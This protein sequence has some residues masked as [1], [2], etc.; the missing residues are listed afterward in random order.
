MSEVRKGAGRQTTYM[1]AGVVAVV[2][3]A[4]ILLSYSGNIFGSTGLQTA[5]QAKPA[6]ETQTTQSAPA[7]Q[8]AGEQTQAETAP[9]EAEPAV[10]EPSQPGGGETAQDVVSHT[11]EINSS[12]FVPETLTI[13]AGET[14]TFVNNLHLSSSWPASAVHPTHRIYPGSD[15]GKCGTTEEPEIFDACRGLEPGETYS[16]TFN[17]EG[18][19]RYHDHFNPS[20]TGTIIVQ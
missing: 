7:E 6:T 18:K 5:S 15:I 19:W 4:G 16:F 17:E 13:S 3:V 2:V 9:A 14:V 1:I 8:P 10:E 11:V 20:T 12:G